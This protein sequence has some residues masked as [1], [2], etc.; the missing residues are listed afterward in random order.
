L[1]SE[2][3]YLLKPGAKIASTNKTNETD[4]NSTARPRRRSQPVDISQS[5][6]GVPKVNGPVSVAR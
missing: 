5:A 6:R 2:E 1:L 4:K 3:I